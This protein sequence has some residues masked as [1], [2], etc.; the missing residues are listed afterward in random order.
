MTNEELAVKVKNGDENALIELWHQN[1][2]LAVRISRRRY[3]QQ[4]SYGGLCGVDMDDFMQ[5]A[6]LALV[7][8]VSYYD[9]KKDAPFNT[10]W[11]NCIKSEFNTLLGVRTSKRDA[12]NFCVSLDRALT[13]D[14][15]TD[16]GTL[17]DFIPDPTDSYEESDRNM[18]IEQLHETLE[19]ALSKLTPDQEKVVRLIYYEDLDRASAAAEMGLTYSSCRS[20]EGAAMRILRKP[21]SVRR[22]LEAY[23]DLRTNFYRKGS[24]AQQSSPVEESVILREMW[25]NMG[26]SKLKRIEAS[27]PLDVRHRAVNDSAPINS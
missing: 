2:G 20:L 12:L 4:E 10:Y 17:K 26:L 19:K 6:F 24:V 22:E 1:H 23:I 15:D 5:T 16:D 18:Q 7:K 8:A 21:G 13:V 3:N 25:R 27:N 9:A 14:G 11:T